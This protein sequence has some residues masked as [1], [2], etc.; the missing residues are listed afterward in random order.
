MVQLTGLLQQRR[1]VNKNRGF[2]TYTGKYDGGELTIACHGIG[3]PSVAIV[4]EELAML[5]AR[6]IVRLGTCGGLVRDMKVGDIVIATEAGYE[7]GAL[8]QYL[9]KKVVPKPDATLTR[10]LEESVRSQGVSYYRGPVFSSDAFYAED[11]DHVRAYSQKG[12]IAVEM[13]CATLFGLGTL[14]KVR[15][16]SMLLVSDNITED[17]PIVDARVLGRYAARAGRLVFAALGRLK[18]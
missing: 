3:G 2:L 6:A 5:G 10:L 7:G 12:Y 18:V 4:V 14:R 15:T 11:S 13:E 9:G 16:A 1:L 17:A 8:Q